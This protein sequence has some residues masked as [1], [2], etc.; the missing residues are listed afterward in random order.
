MEF[1]HVPV[2]LKECIDGL[3]IKA[4]GIYVDCTVGGAGHSSEIAERL[5][6]NGRLREKD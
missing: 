5:G 4:D 1:H 6:E 3:N 2:M